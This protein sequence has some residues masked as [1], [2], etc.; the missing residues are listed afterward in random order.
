MRPAE[1]KS[2]V[3]AFSVGKPIENGGVARVLKSKNAA[4]KEGALIYGGLPFS[5]YVVL[6]EQ[7]AKGF[8]DVSD[9][10]ISPETLVGAC[11]MPG[12]TAYMSLYNVGK[13]QKGESIFVSAGE[14]LFTVTVAIYLTSNCRFWRRR[15]FSHSVRKEKRF[16]GE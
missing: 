1:I 10:G 12:R 8:K 16:E 3:P 4:L 14:A 5:E 9:S 13:P 6:N 2:Y 15:V 11:G 7:A